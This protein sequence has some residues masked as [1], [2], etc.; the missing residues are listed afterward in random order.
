MD[1]GD[2][3]K[4]RNLMLTSSGVVAA[5]FLR[6]KIPT[7]TVGFLP[8]HA[9]L[10]VEVW[11][12]W[13]IVLAVLVYQTWR[14]LTDPAA[15][16]ARAKATEF[17]TN[18]VGSYAPDSIGAAARATVHRRSKLG[19]RIELMGDLPDAEGFDPKRSLV[20]I[21]VQDS[22]GQILPWDTWIGRRGECGV[23]YELREMGGQRS[24]S[25]GVSA[26][27]TLPIWQPISWYLRAAHATLW[28]SPD[29]QD[30]LVPLVLA[31]IAVAGSATR[32]LHL[33]GA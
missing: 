29:C 4:R 8:I 15:K 17:F 9:E 27:Y 25:S 2:S 24:W 1:E 10:V 6:L 11:R 19:Y 7:A 13:A 20:G 28:H 12:V 31:V 3:K 22:G 32:L 18:R 14:F 26:K 16:L 21:R 23:F 5:L 30:L 33:I